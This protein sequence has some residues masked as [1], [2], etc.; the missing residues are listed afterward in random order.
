MSISVQLQ[1]IAIMS[2]CG[3]LMGI[4]FDTYQLFRRKRRVPAWLVF[5]LDLCFWL[6]SVLLVFA[7]LREINDGIVRW[8]IFIGMLGGAWLY[9]TLGSKMYTQLLLAVIKCIRWLYRTVLTIMDILIVQPIL[10]FYKLISILLGFVFSVLLAIGSFLWKIVLFVTNPFAKWS[11]HIGKG[12]G[13]TGA[14][15]WARMK[16]W[17]LPRKKR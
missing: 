4:G 8:P 3:V 6:T 9:F 16:N 1:T 11:Q 13:R 2:A 5:L 10:F 17:L 12:L 15:V 14:G 7:V